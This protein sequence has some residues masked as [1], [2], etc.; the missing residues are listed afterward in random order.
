[1]G[2]VR[3]K[4]IASSYAFMFDTYPFLQQWVD[5]LSNNGSLRDTFIL[6]TDDISL[7]ALYLYSD[8]VTP[9]TAVIV[10]GYTDNAVRMLHIAYL[11]NHDL[12]Y[13]VLLPDLRYSGLSDGTHIQMGWNDRFDVLQW[14]DVANKIFSPP[15]GNTQMVVH[16]ISMGAATTMCVSGEKVQP[17]VNCFIEDCGYTSVWDEF[18]SELKSRF[19]LPAFPLLHL[20]NL[21]TDLRYGWNFR[22]ASP[23]KQLKK[24]NR[25]MLFIHGADD[26]FVPTYMGDTLFAAFQGTK[27]YWRVEGAGHAESYLKH[28]DEYTA[29][30]KNFLDTYNTTRK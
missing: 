4:N 26:T 20:S 3:G 7:H 24:C 15:Y 16:G 21:A 10:H 25:P 8:T 11:Y 22:E 13:N 23:L 5:S 2:N 14:M 1:M 27:Q 28:K 19:S 12:H 17:F 6:S 30:V 18:K 29:I 9:N